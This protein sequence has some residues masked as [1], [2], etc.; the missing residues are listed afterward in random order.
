MS[1]NL[2][3][4]AVSLYFNEDET[5]DVA[6]KLLEEGFLLAEHRRERRF[7]K[8]VNEYKTAQNVAK[9]NRVSSRGDKSNSSIAVVVDKWQ[10]R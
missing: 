10:G 6:L 3:G 2:L 8:M 1:L 9:K 5:G 4:D 7:Q